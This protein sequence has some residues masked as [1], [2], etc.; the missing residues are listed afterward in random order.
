MG[1]ASTSLTP[2]GTLAAQQAAFNIG[3]MTEAGAGTPPDL[4]LRPAGSSTLSK[5][6]FWPHAN[7]EMRSEDTSHA[8]RPHYRLIRSLLTA[9]RSHGRTQ[10]FEQNGRTS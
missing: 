10:P 9:A 6:R 7:I 1:M 5:L 2:Q 3:E 4:F 8:M